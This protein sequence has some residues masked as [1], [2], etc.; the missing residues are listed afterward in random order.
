MTE[1]ESESVSRDPADDIYSVEAIRKFANEA[2]P[3][4]G[5]RVVEE[6]EY[7]SVLCR[8]AWKLST[9]GMTREEA[10]ELLKR[11]NYPEE[12]NPKIVEVDFS[13]GPT[14]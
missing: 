6:G 2:D 10:A 4:T 13:E 7:H 1:Y 9:G 3:V 5:K 12:R 11:Y 14:L 8:V